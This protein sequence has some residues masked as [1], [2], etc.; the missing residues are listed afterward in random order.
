VGEHHA[1]AGADEVGDHPAV[2][3]AHDGAGGNAQH[4]VLAPG[5]VAV[6]AGAGPAVARLL[7]RAVVEVQQGVHVRVDLE[8]DVAAVPTVAAVRAAERLELLAVHRGHAV[9]AVAR[10]HVHGHPVHERGHERGL[11]PARKHRHPDVG[12]DAGVP[13]RNDCGP[14]AGSRRER[15]SGGG[16]RGPSTG[17]R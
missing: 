17:P 12:S 16:Q 2:G 14:S 6:A 9:A 7:V 5:A 4:G 11:L 15:A 1:G 3:G 8:D 13:V 10:G